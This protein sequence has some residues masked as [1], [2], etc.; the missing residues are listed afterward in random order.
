M[1]YIV[2][3]HAGMRC[4]VKLTSTQVEVVVCGPYE[5]SMACL[6]SQYES[7]AHADHVQVGGAVRSLH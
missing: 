4:D 7:E 3:I 6:C 1:L 5:K 2:A